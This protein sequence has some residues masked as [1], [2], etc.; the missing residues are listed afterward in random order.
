M[1]LLHPPHPRPT[2]PICIQERPFWYSIKTEGSS[3]LRGTPSLEPIYIYTHT[4]TPLSHP[5]FRLA[6]KR[7]PVATS[8]SFIRRIIAG[9]VHGDDVGPSV[10]ENAVD[11]VMTC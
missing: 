4:F 7:Y 3:K 1:T 10:I 2:P 8:G 5:G 6:K 9:R 11:L